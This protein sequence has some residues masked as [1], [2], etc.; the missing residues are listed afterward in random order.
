MT[1]PYYTDLDTRQKIDKL[2]KDCASIFSNL[3]TGT[4]FDLKTDAA[5]DA[6]EQSLLLQI[7]ELDGEFYNTKLLIEK[8]L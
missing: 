5:A 6:K 7:K 3:G 1:T 4:S 2:L 8:K